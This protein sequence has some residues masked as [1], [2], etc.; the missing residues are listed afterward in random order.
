MRNSYS[1]VSPSEK[2]LKEEKSKAYPLA[3]RFKVHFVWVGFLL[4]TLVLG[5]SYKWYK[6]AYLQPNS[7]GKLS[8]SYNN[9]QTPCTVKISYQLSKRRPGD[10]I[11]IDYGYQARYKSYEDRMDYLVTRDS[12]FVNHTYFLPTVYSMKLKSKAGDVLDSQWVYVNSRD[13]EL[14]FVEAQKFDQRKK[15]KVEGGLAVLDPS[16]IDK[17]ITTPSEMR[18]EFRN[19]NEQ[20]HKI[21]G[22]SLSLECDSS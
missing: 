16:L 6:F 20:F 3:S 9:K 4:F 21:D 11:Y 8:I 22:D 13:F 10:S 1:D 5:V 18:M 14:H 17:P 2:Q 15:Y 12:G 7:E 19:F